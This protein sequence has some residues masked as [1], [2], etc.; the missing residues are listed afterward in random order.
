MY[1]QLLLEIEADQDMSNDPGSLMDTVTGGIIAAC[2]VYYL[3]FAS[4]PSVLN[5]FS[6]NDSAAMLE[7]SDYLNT[8]LRDPTSS[9]LLETIVSRSPD[10]AF[11]A[12]W[13]TYFQG[14]LARLALHP[15]A[16]FVLAKALER[17]SVDRLVVACGELEGN[18][19]KII[20]MWLTV[21]RGRRVSMSLH[22]IVKDRRPTSH[23]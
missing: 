18:W 23:H 17:V 12:L 21:T 3:A 20:S 7:T 13:S 2:C 22:R 11:V 16:N 10:N 6:A 9:H 1:L 14:K 15:V 4:R 8:L 19:G 5:P